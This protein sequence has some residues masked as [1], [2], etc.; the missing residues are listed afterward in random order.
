MVRPATGTAMMMR[1]AKRWIVP[2]VIAALMVLEVALTVSDWL[3][4]AGFR[5]APALDTSP[6]AAAPAPASLARAPGR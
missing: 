2:G 5:A 3:G 1:S 4:P 6:A